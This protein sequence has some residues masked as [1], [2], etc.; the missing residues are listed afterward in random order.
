MIV[1]ETKQYLWPDWGGRRINYSCNQRHGIYG[2]TL[3]HEWGFRLN[4]LQI[5]SKAG[6]GASRQNLAFRLSLSL[7]AE[8]REIIYCYDPDPGKVRSIIDKLINLQSAI[9]H[10]V[11]GKWVAGRC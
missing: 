1:P 9:N 8:A 11:A 6:A 4:L 7:T 5:Y 10:G 3:R 2:V